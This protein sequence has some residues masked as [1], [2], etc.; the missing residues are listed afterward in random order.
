MVRSAELVVPC[1]ASGVRAAW[2]CNNLNNGGNCGLAARNSNN[3]T[4]NSNW[5]GSVGVPS[6]FPSFVHLRHNAP[7]ITL[8]IAK[9]A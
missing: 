8:R 4:G 3:S 7:Y 6:G 1:A 2:C 5:N 9:I